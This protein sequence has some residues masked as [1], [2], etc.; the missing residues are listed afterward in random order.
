MITATKYFSVLRLSLVDLLS[1]IILYFMNSTFL[2]VAVNMI[3]TDYKHI[4]YMCAPPDDLVIVCGKKGRQWKLTQ[5]SLHD[6]TEMSDIKLDK[7]PDGMALVT[8]AGRPCLA[9]SYM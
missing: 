2:I 1:Q 7:R 9:L 3:G 8:L 4:A 5:Y 6:G